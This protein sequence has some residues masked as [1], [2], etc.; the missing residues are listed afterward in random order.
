MKRTLSIIITALL[1]AS[2]LI[3]AYGCESATQNNDDIP[4]K[5][6][7]EYDSSAENA[8]VAFGKAETLQTLALD[9]S[10]YEAVKA[11][12]DAI[13][14]QNANGF[15]TTNAIELLYANGNDNIFVADDKLAKAFIVFENGET[16]SLP[17]TDDTRDSVRATIS[18]YTTTVTYDFIVKTTQSDG[19]F[20]LNVSDKSGRSWTIDDK[21]IIAPSNYKVL[22]GDGSGN[23]YIMYTGGSDPNP[24]FYRYIARYSSGGALLTGKFS[25]K[26]LADM[27][28]V[29]AFSESQIVDAENVCI[30]TLAVASDGIRI[31]RI[32]L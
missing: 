28:G 12:V 30:Y 8:D 1:I 21:A 22:F 26:L 9:A 27:D 24:D 5:N 23:L 31:I 4:G 18:D 6:M 10:T 11:E 29:A 19:A 20:H 2:M 16:R 15:I 17:Y 7:T 25:Y 32:A 14:K 3:F 13:D